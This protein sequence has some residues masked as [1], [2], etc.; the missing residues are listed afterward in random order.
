MK[1]TVCFLLKMQDP[2]TTS[3]AVSSNSTQSV[4]TFVPDKAISGKHCIAR[5][6][7]MGYT[8]DDT[9]LS[10]RIF[11]L[12]CSLPQLTSSYHCNY[13]TSDTV[14]RNPT[15]FPTTS[16][17]DFN[18]TTSNVLTIVYSTTNRQAT[19]FPEF[20]TY[21]Q[22]GPQDVTFTM[23]QP[24]T[25]NLQSPNSGVWLLFEMEPID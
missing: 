17:P 24:R 9:F 11:F 19:I 5:L 20:I 15:L 4:V 2:T 18:F 14:W 7:N 21:I 22:E 6:V 25:G 8:R 12:T 10:T 1:S 13:K 23:Q 3:T 16:Q